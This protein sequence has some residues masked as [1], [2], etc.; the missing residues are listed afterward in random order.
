MASKMALAA[1]WS[2][3][4][5]THPQLTDTPDILKV[6]YHAMALIIAEHQLA[7]AERRVDKHGRALS[8]Y[9]TLVTFKESMKNL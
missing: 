8:Q 6:T 9:K 4:I 1:Q 3:K 7:K 2:L 5:L